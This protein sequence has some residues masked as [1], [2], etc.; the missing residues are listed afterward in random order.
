MNKIIILDKLEELINS[1]NSLPAYQPNHN[2][3]Y[4]KWYFRINSL[5]ES[6][7]TLK[8]YTSTLE[9]FKFEDDTV[10]ISLDEVHERTEELNRYNKSLRDIKALLESL[11]DAV[12]GWENSPEEEAQ[13]KIKA[14]LETRNL[15]EKDAHLFKRFEV[16]EQLE[17]FRLQ[18]KNY[19]ESIYGK[20][21]DAYKK[22]KNINFL[23]Y[24]YRGM[25][26]KQVPLDLST[27][28]DGLKTAKILLETICEDIREKSMK[29]PVA[30]PE[31]STSIT[32]KVLSN[33]VFIVHGHDETAISQLSEVLLRLKLEPIVLRDNPSG[34]NT[35]IEKIERLSTSVG[36]GIALYT[37]C[38]IGGKTK[39]IL[40][41]RARQNVLFEHGYLMAKIGR[42]NT[43]ALV[44]GD[45]E[46]PS[47]LRGVVYEP[48][49][50]SGAWKFKIAS[51]LKHN[52]YD[53]DLNDLI[54]H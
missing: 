29:T 2:Q 42:K 24:G 34:G 19:L 6:T 23:Y 39:D 43:I 27:Y 50:D 44:K 35:V 53:I 16:N 46:I 20:D 22:F 3:E 40:K 8:K 18:V 49:D 13:F 17:K 15:L 26:G 14:F 21:S 31:L 37:A 11:S 10:K 4:N 1:S 12:R 7:E 48:M 41:N 36:Y 52:G 45:I 9:N 30:I 38:D 54:K 47:D 32:P 51:E 25:E 5:L 28:K 33:K